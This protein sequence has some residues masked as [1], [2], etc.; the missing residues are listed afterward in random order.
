MRPLIPITSTPVLAA[1]AVKAKSLFKDSPLPVDLTAEVTAKLEAKL[2]LAQ[3]VE[4]QRHELAVQAERER[5]HRQ[6]LERVRKRREES[7]K[8]AFKMAKDRLQ[9]FTPGTMVEAWCTGFRETCDLFE[10][11]KDYALKLFFSRIS[12]DSG[13]WI[14]EFRD[15]D[16]QK[17]QKVTDVDRWIARLQRTYRQSYETQ[18]QMV[19]NIRQD[20]HEAADAFVQRFRA[21]A[22]AANKDWSKA[23]I[24]NMI[25][26]SVHPRWRQ[27]FI[28]FNNGSKDFPDVT[29]ALSKAMST[30]MESFRQMIGRGA[31]AT[32]SAGSMTAASA[33]FG[34]QNEF[35]GQQTQSRSRRGSRSQNQVQ[36]NAAQSGHWNNSNR[37]NQNQR[38]PPGNCMQC[39]QPGHWKRECPVLSMDPAA[40]QTLID[41]ASQRLQMDQNGSNSGNSQPNSGSKNGQRRE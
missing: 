14:T 7:M 12:T 24:V 3:A 10:L 22:K 35:N 16:R 5:V 20:E 1:A 29:S 4:Q 31:A 37:Q 15:D 23:E 25:Q 18:L 11:D 19:K 17:G 39:G 33:S 21:K 28:L 13:S 40:L 9:M 30:G 6:D 26:D 34:N 41:A 32:A 36:G 38:T 27:A 2:F 8:E